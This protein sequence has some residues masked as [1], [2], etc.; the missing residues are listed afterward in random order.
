MDPD[1]RILLSLRQIAVYSP[2]NIQE[3]A[4]V[5]FQLSNERPL[6]CGFFLAHKSRN[7][8]YLTF[9]AAR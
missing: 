8:F 6:F 7:E 4:S 1:C 3:I 5:V 2:D 9:P